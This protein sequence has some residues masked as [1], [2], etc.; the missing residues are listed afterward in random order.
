M[1]L[2]I[3]IIPPYHP[4]SISHL[5]IHPPPIYLI[6]KPTHG[7]PTLHQSTSNTCAPTRPSHHFTGAPISVC[8]LS[9]QIILYSFGNCIKYLLISN[10]Y[11]RFFPSH[12]WHFLPEKSNPCHPWLGH[13]N[14]HSHIYK[15]SFSVAKPR[16]S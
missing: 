8:V 5:Q 16:V 10:K 1:H 12:R 6:H 14:F 2:H 3:F 13:P 11:N 15:I 7:A 4:T 9:T